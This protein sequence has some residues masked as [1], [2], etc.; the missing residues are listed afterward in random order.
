M[1]NTRPKDFD[2]LPKKTQ[3]SWNQWVNQVPVL[4]FNSGKYDL[5]L[6][7]EHFVTVMTEEGAKNIGVA[8]KENKFMFLTTPELK[9]LDVL[10][11]LGPGFNFDGWCKANN[12]ET[13][14]LVFPYDWLD[15]YEKLEHEGPVQREHFSSKLKGNEIDESKCNFFVEE[16][17]KRGCRTI[18]D[19]LKE[20]NLADVIP[21]VEAL[22]KTREQY[23]PDGIDML[24]DA[25]SISG[26]SMIYV[27]NKSLE[28]DK[29][30]KLYAPGDPC[31]CKCEEECTEFGCE[32]CKEVR[33]N[34]TSCTGNRAYELL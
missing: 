15:S 18:R 34:C 11:Y 1:N 20:Y 13:Q 21:F 10:N 25:V 33:E 16:F 27:L 31:Y 22:E 3:I 9:F 8:K 14:K 7:K 26:I 32:E 17:H 30:L 12:C 28:R 29:K 19:W 4:G 23:Y 5:N 24:K 2:R 6:I